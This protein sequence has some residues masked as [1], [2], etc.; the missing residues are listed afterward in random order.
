M[1][2]GTLV[3]EPLLGHNEV[4]SECQNIAHTLFLLKFPLNNQIYRFWQSLGEEPV[5]LGLQTHDNYEDQE[6]ISFQFLGFL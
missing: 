4:F 6:G 5:F 2:R 1:E 3:F